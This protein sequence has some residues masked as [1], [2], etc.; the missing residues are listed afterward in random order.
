MSDILSLILSRER[1]TAEWKRILHRNVCLERRR[2]KEDSI[3]FSVLHRQIT[4]QAIHV[5]I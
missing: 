5:L 1:G 4:M 2:K 3:L